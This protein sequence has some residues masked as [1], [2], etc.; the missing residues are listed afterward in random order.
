MAK[1]IC[2]HCGGDQFMAIIKRGGIV[3]SEG[4]DTDGNVIFKIVKEGAKNN[5]D[6]D[7][8]KCMKCQ[9]TVTNGDLAEGATCKQCG[10]VVGHGELDADGLCSVCTMLKEDPAIGNMSAD[11]LRILL[12]QSRKQLS[13]VNKN[14]ESK[15]AAAEKVEEKVAAAAVEESKTESGE[16]VLAGI[17]GDPAPVPVAQEEEKTEEKPKR[18][19]RARKRN[20][21]AAENTEATEEQS[22]P[23]PEGEKSEE[24]AS[25]V[26]D[27]Q[28][29]Q[30]EKEL[31]DGNAPFPEVDGAMN[32]PE[33]EQPQSSNPGNISGFQMYDDS[34]E[35]PF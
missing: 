9:S 14:V 23:E 17:M 19:P 21:S 1:K 33:P 18:R 30:A 28:A 12:A 5:F 11:E 10:R 20:A 25:D 13:M 2:P 22:E 16:D 26:T 7:I 15:K 24:E 6:V 34:T 3:I 4:T 29:E 8:V 32:L 27:A 31:A 35:Q